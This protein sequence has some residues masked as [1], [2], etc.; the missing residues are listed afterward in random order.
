LR[1]WVEGEP[2]APELELDVLEASLA[3]SDERI[4]TYLGRYQTNLPPNSKTAAFHWALAGGDPANG[5]KLFIE[6]PAAACYR[7]HAVEGAG[8]EVGPKMDGIAGRVTPNHLLEAIVEPNA[9]IAEGF[10]NLLIELKNGTFQ[11]GIIKRETDTEL[12]IHSV[13]GL[14]TLTKADIQSRERGLSGMPEGIEQILS[15][16]ELRDVMAFLQSLK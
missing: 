16:Q 12:A 11:S 13:D 8:G 7:C 14:I 10:E 1:P 6:H 2:L 4:K 9:K 5:R 15:K 3:R